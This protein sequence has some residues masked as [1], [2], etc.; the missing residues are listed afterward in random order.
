[1]S[2]KRNIFIFS[3]KKYKILAQKPEKINWNEIW[4]KLQNARLDL[5]VLVHQR[6]WC[7]SARS[8]GCAQ[9]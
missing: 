7:K 1:M 2:E 9:L 8:C 3:N 5:V 4:K 6:W